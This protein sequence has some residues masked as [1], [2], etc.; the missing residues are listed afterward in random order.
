[1]IPPVVIC[2]GIMNR[3]DMPRVESSFEAPGQLRLSEGFFP[4]LPKIIVGSDV[5]I[6]FLEKFLQSL[7]WLPCEV[8]RCRSWPELLDHSLNDDLIGHCRCL[9]SQPQEP[10][11]IHLQVLLLVLRT[12]KERLGSVR[13]RLKTLKAGH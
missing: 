9:S 2:T 13:L 7:R 6:H 5:L 1:M 8:L 12:L 10:S 3:P 11:D 4:S